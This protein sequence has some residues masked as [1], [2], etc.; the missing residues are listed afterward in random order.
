ML[1]YNPNKDAKSQFYDLLNESLKI[2]RAKVSESDV[3]FGDPTEV[4]DPTSEPVK[5]TYNRINLTKAIHAATGVLNFTDSN[6]KYIDDINL[7]RKFLSICNVRITA[8]DITMTRRDTERLIQ[9]EF[10]VKEG[11]YCLN[12]TAVMNISNEID[13]LEETFYG[14]YLRGFNDP[15][16]TAHPGH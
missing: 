3:T 4:F 11:H 6:S 12:G 5:L 14:D 9:A 1:K 13:T 8:N 10:R 7:I 15:D 2:P 16:P